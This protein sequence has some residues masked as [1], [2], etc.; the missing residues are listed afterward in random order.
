MNK[1]KKLSL[2]SF[3][4]SFLLFT[5]FAITGFRLNL[6]IVHTMAIPYTTAIALLLL[7]LMLLSIPMNF[8][9]NVASFYIS[10]YVSLAMFLTLVFT[11]GEA[12][13]SIVLVGFVLYLLFVG[14]NSRSIP[15][16]K[17]RVTTFFATLTLIAF[18]GG[19][20]S[21]YDQH[22]DVPITIETASTMF[23]GVGHSLPILEK[24]GIFII[25]KYVEIT[26]S[27]IELLI[28]LGISSLVSENYFLIISYI[29]NKRSKYGRVG[30]A[31]YGVTGALSCQCESYIALLPAVSAFLLDEVLLPTVFSSLALLVLTYILVSKYYMH[32]RHL[33]IFEPW[34]WEKGNSRQFLFLS[35]SLI[36]APLIITLGVSLDLQRNPI[37]FFISSMYMVLVGYIFSYSISRFIKPVNRSRKFNTLLTSIGIIIPLIWYLPYLTY[38]AF[39]NGLFFDLMSLTGFSGG[40]MMGYAFTHST[41]TEG[42][43]LNEYITVIFSI[44]PLA[45]FYMGNVLE[46]K[47]WSVFS[48][49]GQ[50][51][52]SLLNWLIMLP[53]MWFATHVSLQNL[54]EDKMPENDKFQDLAFLDM[55]PLSIHS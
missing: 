20:I 22:Y 19:I 36:T 39:N 49:E 52:Y 29:G 30:A 37:F 42:Y 44:F 11:V 13:F 46:L 2:I 9:P 35:T 33:H 25:T 47:I 24:F 54:V 45:I 40:I 17:I 5:E 38:A 12:S 28:F 15:G 8:R 7:L 6:F 51:I 48:L 32:N 27:P 3:F 53:I 55:N 23:I 18:L 34:K 14:L 26:V 50:I 41:R 43:A 10:L 31:L 4:I 21:I 1:P 16:K